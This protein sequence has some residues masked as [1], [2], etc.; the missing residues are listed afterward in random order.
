[1]NKQKTICGTQR[2]SHIPDGREAKQCAQCEAWFH[3]P[4]CHA[5]RHRC[6]SE[7][8]SA[9]MRAA[10]KRQRERR[11]AICGDTFSPRPRQVRLGQGIV[12][13]TQCLGKLLQTYKTTEM[14]K[15]R[16]AGMRA[17]IAAGAW[18]FLRGQ[19]NPLWEGGPIASRKRRTESGKSAAT[20][21][22]YRKKHPHKVREWSAKRGDR[23]TG[24]LPYGTIPTLYKK[25]KGKCAHCAAALNAKYH[26]DHIMPLARGGKHEALNIQL[27][28]PTC[29]LRKGAK[30]PIRFAN[31]AGRLL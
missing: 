13:S 19:E 7:K 10:A 11:C 12:C 24:R 6:C 16:L 27:L 30:D 4:R 2:P 3:L 5:K 20:L 29:N 15:K 17:K 21:R 9:D 23:R 8:C 18:T 31:E 25:Q 28:C 22:A 1:M 14:E 26:A